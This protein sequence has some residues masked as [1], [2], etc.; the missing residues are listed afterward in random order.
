MLDAWSQVEAGRGINEL[1]PLLLVINRHHLKPLV[2][3]A[4]R[5][6]ACAEATGLVL[7]DV[8]LAVDAVHGGLVPI[9]CLRAGNE[10]SLPLFSP[11]GGRIA[12]WVLVLV[13]GA[14]ALSDAAFAA[15]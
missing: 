13:A 15:N 11:L 1:A 12:S 3:K 10:P 9:A 14:L 8:I 5:A 4:A 6:I 2:S 7:G